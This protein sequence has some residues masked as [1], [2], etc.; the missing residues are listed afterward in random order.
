VVGLH[1]FEQKLNQIEGAN[2]LHLRAGYFMENSLPQAAAIRMTGSTVGPLRPDLKVSMIASRDI[3]KAAAKAM[4]SRDFL[5][6]QARELH[7]NRELSY[8][9]ATAIIGKAVGKPD[10]KYIQAPDDQILGAMVQMGMSEDMARQIIEMAGALNSGYMRP[11]E[12]RTPESTTET[13]FEDFVA[14]FF[15][16]A[17][18]Q[19]KAA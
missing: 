6:K 5:G 13:T 2:V 8:N 7:G 12:A 9:D 10:L 3:G 11:L 14:E 19:Q 4:F 16:P 1:N 18:Q 17:Y 15:V